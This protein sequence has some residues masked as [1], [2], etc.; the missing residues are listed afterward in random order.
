MKKLLS[1]C[2]L[3]LF[4]VCAMAQSGTLSGLIVDQKT[5]EPLIGATVMVENTS[6]GVTTDL[7]GRFSMELQTGKYNILIKYIGYAQRRYPDV[8]INPG[9]VTVLQIS[10]SEENTAL[11]EIVVVSEARRDK[12]SAIFIMQKNSTVIQS[13]ISNEEMK[14]SPDRSSGEV[15]RRVSG[16][17]IQDGKFAVI[18]GL[19]DRYNMAML[20]NIVLPSTEP[21][22]KAFA[23]DVFP[24]NLLDNIL[25]MKTGQSDLPSEWSGGLIQLNTREIP[26]KNFIQVSIGQT[27]TEQTT[28]RPFMSYEGSKTDFLGFDRSVRT[29]PDG[30]PGIVELNDIKLSLAIPKDSLVSLGRRINNSSWK[31][32]NRGLAYPGQSLQL[33]G[34][35]SKR[36]KDSQLGAIFAVTYSNNLRY[37]SGTRTRYDGLD[38]ALYYD[39]DDERYNNS[40]AAALLANLAAVIKK[41]HKLS[42][43]NVYTINSDNN[44]YLR[45]GVNFFSAAEQRRTS[46]EFSSARVFSSNL[47]GEHVF[48]EREIKWRWNGGLVL[49][50]R[51]QPKTMRYSYERFYTSPEPGLP[52]Q[53]TAPF[54]YQIQAGG[55][56]PKLS[57]LFY[58]ELREKV[59]TANTDLSIPFLAGT[60]KQQLKLGYYFQYR[61]RTFSGRNL[62]FDY[63]SQNYSSDTTLQEDVDQIINDQNFVNGKLTL[64]Q[65]AFPTDQ[66]TARSMTNAAFVMMENHI[67]KRIKAVWGFRF[68]HFRQ[69][70]TSPTNLDFEVLDNPDPQLPPIIKTKLTDSTYVK[71]YYSG[72]YKS[73]SAENVKPILPILPSLNVIFKISEDMN[74]RISYSQSMS[75][76]EFRECSPFLYYDFIRDIQLGGNTGLLQTFIHNADLRYEYFMGKGQGVNFSVFYKHFTNT[77]EQTAISAGGVQQFLYSNAQQAQLVGAE[78]EIRKNFGFITPALENLSFMANL[79]YIYSRVNLDNVKNNAGEELKRPMQG[80]SPYIINLGLN[81]LHPKTGTGVTL[82]YNQVGDRLYAVGEVGNPS[83]YEHFRPLL[84]LQLSQKVWKDRLT[85]RLTCSDLIA[86]PTLFYQNDRPDFKRAYQ[87][88]RDL[89]VQSER[90]FRSYTLQLNFNF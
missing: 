64:N 82:L 37:S 54:I 72:F 43:K 87:K 51:D 83:W 4:S 41:K 65:V 76:P 19:A 85:I 39:Y 52:N 75:R 59:Y 55:S 80:Q 34:G 1:L 88:E 8:T 90:N 84:D 31:V 66:Y 77:I 56:D 18:R 5:A 40:V 32:R 6:N 9:K 2:N 10:L 73:D 11:E 48:G 70:L 47:S 15:I 49:I 30:F 17:T 14:R 38:K 61:T 25:I 33:S 78:L 69:Q 21:D 3:L 12:E 89:V 79:A 24:S 62:F 46:L 60:Q 16:A 63:T 36:I 27:F 58:S 45:S 20:N 29:L 44:T 13:G 57:A 74:F 26:D 22:R 42:F 86:R 28:F 68:E 53:S 81:Y 50:S 71:D 7:D 23:F 67:G 35:F